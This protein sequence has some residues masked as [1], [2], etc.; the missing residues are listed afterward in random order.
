MPGEVPKWLKIGTQKGEKKNN[1]KNIFLNIFDWISNLQFRENWRPSQ[2]K[3]LFFNFTL[4]EIRDRKLIEILR[5]LVGKLIENLSKIGASRLKIGNW[6]SKT[7]LEDH[8]VGSSSPGATTGGGR[9]V[10]GA[11]VLTPL[12]QKAVFSLEE[13]FKNGKPRKG[14][15]VEKKNLLLK[16][17]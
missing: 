15:P 16:N 7:V 2:A 17:E 5:I 6:R 14:K 10:T 9:P 1:K 13:C 4:F 3:T 8:G 11:R 12:L